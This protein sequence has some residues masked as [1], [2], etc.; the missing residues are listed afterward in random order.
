MDPK[1]HRMLEDFLKN[2]NTENIEELNEDLQEW[3][4]KY[5]AGEIDYELTILDQANEILDEAYHTN[6]PKKAMKLAK[7]AY[8]MCPACFD[9]LLYQV[10]LEEDYVKADRM[11][12]KGLQKEKQRLEEEGFFTKDYIGI[13]Y[14]VFETRPYIRG[15]RVKIQHLIY[16]G[17]LTMA[18][19]LCQEV[20]QLNES[21]NTGV[22]Y[23]LMAIY[24]MLEEE[25]EM[26][27]LYKKYSENTLEMLFP[28]F[29]LYYKMGDEKK[30]KKYLTKVLKANPH[31]LDF[32][33]GKIKP[34]PNAIPGTY[35]IG[36]TSEVIMYFSEY[37]FLVAFMVGLPEYLL[38]HAK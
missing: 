5:N 19:A 20:L 7:K 37:T 30:T 35:S 3:V 36:D 23:L 15:L 28:L 12:D 22:R 27:T 1:M 32:F 25:Q 9:A 38:E 17:R 6:D 8:Q 31:V 24:A 13:F 34:N 29:L 14:G 2:A 4:Q 21:D 33:Q 10:D 11:L 26:L 16:A 18:K